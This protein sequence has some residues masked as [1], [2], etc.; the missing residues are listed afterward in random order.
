MAS[1]GYT[2]DPASSNTVTITFNSTTTRYV[3]LN[4][5]ANTGW[6]AGQISEFQVYGPTSGDTQPPT[7]PANLA[8]TQPATA[9][10]R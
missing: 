6:P 2:F 1:A 5:T 10:S 7:A 9:R 8:Y 4:I 3:R